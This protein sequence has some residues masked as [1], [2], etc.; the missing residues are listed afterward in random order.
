MPDIANVAEHLPRMARA[1]PHA[2]AI[3]LARNGAKI[4]YEELDRES[5]RLA[6]GLSR[7]GIGKGTRAV[8]MVTPSLELFSLTFALFKAGA[9]PVMVDPGMGVASLGECLDRARPTAFIGIPRAHAARA[10]LGWA[11]RHLETLVTVGPT[12]LRP[13]GG[14]SLDDVRARGEGGGAALEPV[15]HEDLAAILFTSGSTG[16]PKGA[17]YRHGNFVAQV[18]A[19]REMYGIRAGEI[20]LPTFPLFALFDPALGMTTIVPDMDASRPARVS[21]PNIVRPI[22]E[23]GVTN[24]FGSPALLDTVARWAVPRGVRLPS[25]RRV[26]SAGAPVSPR[27][28]SEFAKLLP[29]GCEIHT[30]YGATESLPIATIASGE[31]LGETRARTDAGDGICVGRV[32]PSAHL[33]VIRISDEPIARWDD[34]LRVEAGEVG[35]LVVRGPQV[36]REYFDD[37]QKTRL[38]KIATSDGAVCHRVGDVG[39]VDPKGRVWF[40]GRKSHR[41]ITKERVLFTERVEGPFNAHPSVRRTA[42]VG[43]PQG[44]ETVAVLCVELR[45]FRGRPAHVKARIER[46]LRE[47]AEKN[48]ETRLVRAFLFHPGFPVD[49]RHN[50]KI[51]REDLAPWAAKQLR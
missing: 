40:C 48:E 3:V 47:I 9:I 26:I 24:M 29:E 50:A 17:V 20:D 49:V 36:T 13:W 32:V 51:R 31:V 5:D 23:H 37:E 21:P 4:T 38:A 6:R 30:P 8:L 41:V 18:E 15:S 11:K 1:Q 19:I 2:A 33:E 46:E 28:M 16:V 34:S 44:G 10:V 12:W 43:V 42:L 27:V 25:L 45:P 14:L 39:W 22:L 35:E 7:S